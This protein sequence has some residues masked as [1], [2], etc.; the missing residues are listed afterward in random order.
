MKQVIFSAIMCLTGIWAQAQS[1]ET[2]HATT[3]ATKLEVKNGIEVI[4]TQNDT[5]A[6]KV[7]ADNAAIL[8]KVVTKYNGSTLKVY[9]I[10]LDADVMTGAVKV[11]I[12]QKNLPEIKAEGSAAIKAAGKW[13]LQNAEINLASGATF[14]GQLDVVGNFN[15]KAV[16]GSGFRGTINA[17]TFKANIMSGAYAK[18][19]GTANFANIYCSSGS[20]Q[21]GKLICQSAEVTAQNASAICIQA[22]KFIKAETDTSSSVTYY[23]QPEGKQLGENSF[24]VKRY[25]NRSSLN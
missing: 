14:T 7:E 10:N 25:T 1:T 22:K 11:Y 18:V 8:Q 16:S 13:K 12:S 20:L 5:V 17:G 19:Q 4:I 9:L 23:G 24:A 3:E 15:V 2:R 21:A 6:L